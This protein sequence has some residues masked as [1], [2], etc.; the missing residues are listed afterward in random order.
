MPATFSVRSAGKL[1]DALAAIGADGIAFTHADGDD[2]LGVA[3]ELA[4][5]SGMPVAYIHQGVELRGAMSAAD[6][7]SLAARLLP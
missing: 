2:Q 4:Y 1:V 7:A 3:A 5:R 6:P